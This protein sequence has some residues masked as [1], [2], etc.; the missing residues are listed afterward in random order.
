MLLKLRHT[1]SA[2]IASLDSLRGVGILGILAVHVQWF[3]SVTAARFNPTVYGD[4]GG[5]NWWAWFATYALADG[6]FVAIFGM[7]FGAGIAILAARS[8]IPESSIARLHY[9]R[10]TALFILGLAH[11]YLLWYGDFLAPFAVC[12]SVAF[13]YRDLSPRR[14]AAFGI[15]LLAVGAA[16]PLILRVGSPWWGAATTLAKAQEYWAPPREA[17]AWEIERYR[18]GWWGQMP[19]RAPMALML[20]T[21][22]LAVRGLWQGTGLMLLGMALF[23][24]RVLSAVLPVKIYLAMVAIGFGVGIPLV[25]YGVD[26][27]STHHWDLG[28]YILVGDQLNYWGALFVALGWIGT[29]LLFCRRGRHL[30]ALA[31]V[32]R[33]ALSNYLMQSVICTTI[34]YGHG[35]GLFG[36]VDRVGQLA[37][38][39]AIWI[40]E[41]VASRLWLRYFLAGPIEWLWR[42][43]TYGRWLPLRAHELPGIGDDDSERPRRSP[44]NPAP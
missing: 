12:G 1:V 2:R 21:F 3:A 4:L 32:G 36:R 6:K 13:L 27:S 25:V 7:L 22:H 28:D 20:E 40:V 38:V 10:M 42:S 43:A 26:H 15:L 18:S 29:V 8:Q 9:R 33:T 41:I 11:A 34:F 17:V 37:L 30:R 23:K 19:H 14:L 44:I 35:L 5:A 16:L 24:L 31:A 39:I